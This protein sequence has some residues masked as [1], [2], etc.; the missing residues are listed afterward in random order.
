MERQI[1]LE[2]NEEKALKVLSVTRCTGIP[3]ALCPM[4]FR[5]DDISL[6]IKGVCQDLL[7]KYNNKD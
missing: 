3:C 6:C 7:E 2:N 4:L 5:K 1:K